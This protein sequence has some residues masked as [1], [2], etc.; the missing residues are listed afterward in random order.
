[1]IR[2]IGVVAFAFGVGCTMPTEVVPPV[3]EDY[4][5]FRHGVLLV[6][7][8]LFNTEESN[9]LIELTPTVTHTWVQVCLDE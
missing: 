7:T 1:M 5:C 6:D 8:L 3:Q 2:E 9:G 4:V